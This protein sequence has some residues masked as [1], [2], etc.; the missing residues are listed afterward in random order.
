[1]RTE[2]EIRALL[3]KLK[4]AYDS[5]RLT[6]YG[7]DFGDALMWVSEEIPTPS[8]Q[9]L[10]KEYNDKIDSFGLQNNDDC[11]L[12]CNNLQM[13]Y[14]NSLGDLINL[15]PVDITMSADINY[16]IYI[17]YGTMRQIKNSMQ[18]AVTLSS[19]TTFG[20]SMTMNTDM[21]LIEHIKPS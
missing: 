18:E 13:K 19:T 1:M 2:E 8:F 4:E 12:S 10:I 14:N 9:I 6:E 5:N 3:D 11:D 17:E 16:Q 20:Y 7:L 15:T 21:T